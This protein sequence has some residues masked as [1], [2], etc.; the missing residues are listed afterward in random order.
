MMMVHDI[1]WSLGIWRVSHEEN[2]R[3]N[4]FHWSLYLIKCI[5]FKAKKN[6]RKSISIIKLI[7]C[8]V[9]LLNQLLKLKNIEFIRYWWWLHLQKYKLGSFNTCTPHE[10]V[11][12]SLLILDHNILI[13]R[14]FKCFKSTNP[15]LSMWLIIIALYWKQNNNKNS[16]FPNV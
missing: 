13:L 12:A 8:E 7:K 4:T 9:V 3:K 14:L 5:S 6:P 1:V 10:A 2:S 15:A 16:S 11:L